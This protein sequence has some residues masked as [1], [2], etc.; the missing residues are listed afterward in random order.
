MY[1]DFI[2][3]LAA[4]ILFGIA[5][6]CLIYILFACCR[7]LYRLRRFKA[8]C[9]QQEPLASLENL[10]MASVVIFARN[11]SEALLK[12]LPAILQQN[13]S[14]GFEVIIV[15]E[16]ASEET[17]MAVGMLKRQYGGKI[18]LT[19]T[20]DGARNLSRKKLGL[21]L[22][23]KAAKGDVVVVSDANAKVN[24]ENWLADLMRPFANP[25]T[26]VVIGCGT[27][28]FPQNRF[29]GRLKM[30]QDV[31]A[32]NAAWLLSAIG[33]KPYR[34]CGYNLAYRR[35]LFFN[36]K[37]FSRSLNL[38]DG[39][40]DIFVN[41]ITN[42]TNT[43]VVLTDASMVKRETY[44]FKKSVR[45]QRLSHLFTGKS[46]PKK[47]R[48][49][50]AT[51]EWCLWILIGCSIAG[52]LVAT[53]LNA[54]GWIAA[55]VLIIVALW[56]TGYAWQKT[57][58]AMQMPAAPIATPFVALFRPMRQMKLKLRSKLSHQV[59]YTWQ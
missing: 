49:I 41:E 31:M 56:L 42:G 38:R 22:G 54:V 11:E 28:E 1:F 10:P 34:G 6:I 19:F 51:V 5:L 35:E 13:Y 29:M 46:L 4:Y 33:N 27:P 17:S 26:E 21:T 24:S 32:D 45:E 57:L 15:N 16:G 9:D 50:F 7:P 44:P 25:A 23:V 8:Q 12:N 2:M 55:T 3:P 36:N 47:W 18:Y 37:G 43:E 52:A 53:L 59:H 48:R 40:D 30:S 14:P 58:R 20:P 39:D